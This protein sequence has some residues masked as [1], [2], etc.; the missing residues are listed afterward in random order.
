MI[1]LEFDPTT[2]IANTGIFQAR[3][4]AA[5]VILDP[6]TG[7]CLAGRSL[8]LRQRTVQNADGVTAANGVLR[9]PEVSVE[10]G[11]R[12]LSSPIRHGQDAHGCM[13]Q[14]GDRFP[15]VVIFLGWHGSRN[16]VS[17]AGRGV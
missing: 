17:L 2:P 4:L 3:A 11:V 8:H 14:L 5:L 9:L 6:L 10:I 13:I 1:G 12:L 15:D 7:W 16:I